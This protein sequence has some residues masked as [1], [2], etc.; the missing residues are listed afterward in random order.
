LAKKQPETRWMW[1]HRKA[2]GGLSLSITVIFVV[3]YLLR[4][5]G[6]EN[7]WLTNLFALL[8]LAAIAVLFYLI[9]VLHYD[10]GL[11]PASK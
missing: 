4:L 3:I 11:R 5:V 10:F 8:G 7:F 6:I 2:A 9:L 1:R